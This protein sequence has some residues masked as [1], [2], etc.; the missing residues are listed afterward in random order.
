MSPLY[1]Q[2]IRKFTRGIRKRITGGPAE[3][4][5]WSLPTRSRFLKGTY[6]PGMAKFFHENLKDNDTFWDVGAHFGYY[7]LIAS[8]TLTDGEVFSCEPSVENRWYL[9][10][11]IGWNRLQNV[12]I[13]PLAVGAEDGTCS[14]GGDGTGS[15]HIGGTGDTITVR[16]ADSLLAKGDCRTPTILKIDVEGEE[17]NVLRGA[18]S[19]LTTTHPMLIVATHGGSVHRE[20][21]AILNEYHYKVYE[22]KKDSLILAVSTEN[23]QGDSWAEGLFE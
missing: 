14:F 8:R 3:G 15:G 2:V 21:V 16:S 4:L 20:C 18:E 9:S 22:S 17:A 19:L 23:D 11:H 13:M 12:T 7:S 10:K 1:K 5:F 6:E